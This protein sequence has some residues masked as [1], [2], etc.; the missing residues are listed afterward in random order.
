MCWLTLEYV[1]LALTGGLR[2][3]RAEGGWLA[4]QSVGR[5]QGS[6]YCWG[7][8]ACSAAA[9][10]RRSWLSSRRMAAITVCGHFTLGGV[11]YQHQPVADGHHLFRPEHPLAHGDR[12]C[13]EHLTVSME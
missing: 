2:Q 5:W 6:P 8:A 1:G 11:R 3:G 12:P 13:P 4:S 9:Q 7:E 10:S